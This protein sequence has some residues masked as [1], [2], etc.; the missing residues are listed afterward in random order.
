MVFNP[1]REPRKRM[2]LEGY[3]YSLE[4]A[5]FITICTLKRELFFS[6]EPAAN[7]IEKYW[8]KIPEKYPN[9]KLNEYVIMPNHI[10]GI[11]QIVGA[12]P[13]VGPCTW[14]PFDGKLWQRGYYERLIRSEEELNIFR[15]YIQLNPVKW[16]EDE[17]NPL[18]MQGPTHGS[19]PTMR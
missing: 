5:Y 15:Q 8:N 12:D 11:L 16:E 6:F 19:A 3:D 10:H 14:P 18:I 2:R 1:E 13:C 7:M 17:E 4:G 9:I